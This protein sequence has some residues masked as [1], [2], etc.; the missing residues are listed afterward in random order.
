MLPDK[1]VLVGSRKQTLA[2]VAPQSFD[3]CSMDVA[4][5]KDVLK[6]NTRV[7]TDLQ[8]SRRRYPSW[9]KL[10]GC[11]MGLIVF[12]SVLKL[13]PAREK[14]ELEIQTAE[15]ITSKSVYDA[16]VAMSRHLA[17]GSPYQLM[18]EATADIGG[19]L[20]QHG[21]LA[22]MYH[23]NILERVDSPRSTRGLLKLGFASSG[24]QNWYRVLPFS[25]ARDA[26]ER[27]LE[28]HEAVLMLT[29]LGAP[30]T[31]EEYNKYRKVLASAFSRHGVDGL[32]CGVGS[33]SVDWASR[34]MLDA[35]MV[36][37]N[38]Y[39]LE[40]AK[41]AVV[42]EIPGPDERNYLADVQDATGTQLIAKAVAKLRYSAS[43]H[44]LTMFLC[45]GIPLA[46][47]PSTKK[48]KRCDID[49]S[50][51]FFVYD[52]VPYQTRSEFLST[53]YCQITKKQSAN[54]SNSKAFQK[55]SRHAFRRE[56]VLI[57]KGVPSNKYRVV[58]PDDIL[59]GAEIK[60]DDRVTA[61]FKSEYARPHRLK[62][63]RLLPVEEMS[64][65]IL[66]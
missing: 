50:G 19:P 47:K 51:V 52:G 11:S 14:F 49:V 54:N 63:T 31:L 53:T 36:H 40:Y 29:Q 9:L 34:T 37:E 13:P 66:A 55:I 26:I 17:R 32:L 38:I 57:L 24:K 2:D 7:P 3:G 4:G 46:D 10:F 61:R 22:Q 30:S 65:L 56:E 41:T 59:A 16:C 62:D 44:L 12:V 23:M 27:M 20:K 6:R 48:R 5:L 18:V 60:D 39:A 1:H 42:T 28:L 58:L 43:I 21:F 33:Y 15:G 35:M 45:I 64:R 25:G 8:D